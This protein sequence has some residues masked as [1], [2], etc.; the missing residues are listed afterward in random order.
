MT[1][2][3][4]LE[5]LLLQLQVL[6]L[7]LQVKVAKKK[8][9]IP[10]L[11]TPK[12]LMLHNGGGDWNF[13]QVNK[14]HSNLWGFTSSLGFEIGYHKWI[15]FSGQLYIARRDNEEG[16]HTVD[17]NN[18]GWWNKNSVGLCLQGNLDVNN[19]TG[20]QLMTLK[21][22]LDSYIARGFEIK[23]HGQ[24]VSTACPG[25]LLLV[26]LRENKYIA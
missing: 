18:P 8:L 21:R 15:A 5:K 17:P 13:N 7:E 25:K 22:E 3:Q 14:H 10:N 26:W 4:Q 11:P 12:I 24:I 2:L 6:Y 19:P 20:W 23:Y 1:I 9:T 16:A